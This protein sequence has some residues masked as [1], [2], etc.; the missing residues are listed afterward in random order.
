MAAHS[1]SLKRRESSIVCQEGT[2]FAFLSFPQKKTLLCKQDC[3]SIMAQPVLLCRGLLLSLLLY[4]ELPSQHVE[5]FQAELAEYR[6]L[7]PVAVT[8]KGSK[9][10]DA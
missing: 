9:K 5:S 4:S 2:S 8:L 3:C 7:T 1:A 10:R 6:P